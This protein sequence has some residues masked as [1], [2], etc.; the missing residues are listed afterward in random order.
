MLFQGLTC[1][2]TVEYTAL[3]GYTSN[4][5]TLTGKT[6]HGTLGYENFGL[7]GQY[8]STNEDD[9]AE[10]LI[11]ADNNGDGYLLSDLT[12]RNLA[13][14]DTA[15][16]VVEDFDNTDFNTEDD[17]IQSVIVGNKYGEPVAFW[18]AKSVVNP[19]TNPAGEIEIRFNPIATYTVAVREDEVFTAVNGTGRSVTFSEAN[20]NEDG[21]AYNDDGVTVYKTL[22][23][24]RTLLDDTTATLGYV[25]GNGTV[26]ELYIVDGSKYMVLRNT[27]LDTVSQAYS[28]KYGTGLE[29][30]DGLDTDAPASAEAT[31]ADFNVGDHVLFNVYGA[32][33][34]I[35]YTTIT[36]AETKT[37]T[38]T[39]SYVREG[40]T[41]WSTCE[42]SYFLVG[43]TTYEYDCNTLDNADEYSDLDFNH[44]D[45][46]LDRNLLLQQDPA[47][48]TQVLYFDEYGYV[49]FSEAVNT[50]TT[51]GY[52]IVTSTEYGGYDKD[53]G[54]YMN[55][56]GYDMDGKSVTV[57]GGFDQY[58]YTNKDDASDY[59]ADIAIYKYTKDLDTGFVNLEADVAEDGGADNE[60][61]AGD[62]DAVSGGD[63]VADNET[64]FVVA[65]YNTK[66][67]ITGY[68]VY[69]GIK[70]IKD[71]KD[72]E[73]GD[74]S[75]V[76][77][78]DYVNWE[79]TYID[80]DIDPE[81][82]ANEDYE[83][84]NVIDLVLVLGAKQSSD[85][86]YTAKDAQIPDIIYI[87]TGVP[88]K[89]FS[90]YNL[91]TAI[92]DGKLTTVK[93][94]VDAEGQADGDY[95]SI[96]ENGAGFYEV[97]A[98]TNGGDYIYGVE[99]VE[100]VEATYAGVD[101]LAM[102]MDSDAIWK[103][104][105]CHGGD[106]ESN[107]G[108][109]VL[110]DNYKMYDITSGE[111]VEITAEDLIIDE[112][113]D[114]NLNELGYTGV[115]AVVADWNNYGFATAVYVISADIG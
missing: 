91:Y 20:A 85:V 90:E 4:A 29:L 49:I 109:V 38:L 61:L 25:G 51:A 36:L 10:Y 110:A 9:E 102:E 60:I 68:D 86:Q 8:L 97:T 27:W 11:S 63:V 18:Y 40:E 104:A 106:G 34:N 26:T 69:T 73:L 67:A 33:R 96:F 37:V 88:E 62:P 66:G 6:T 24:K 28:A 76:I 99:A 83:A 2:Q 94:D 65:N 79:V 98:W 92:V 30:T 113:N 31:L 87:R 111:A 21:E 80:N 45:G 57:Q 22:T 42:S 43:S 59:S 32:D 41:N 71:L 14:A 107:N 112:T 39:N 52:M 56:K 89:Q 12:T 3:L 23:D 46:L 35:D 50:Q 108:Y 47:E 95:E 15:I 58:V 70:N 84:D 64:V 19:V 93:V 114:Y 16:E 77:Y 105:S 101:V 103:Y 1:T 17:T 13:V 54:Y 5:S 78:T 74:K 100:A 55:I 48:D 53:N 72:A 44:G 75:S 115:N 82:P 81:N 7:R